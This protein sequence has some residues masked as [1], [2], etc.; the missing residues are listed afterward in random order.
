[1]PGSNLV[2]R[3]L[4]V[5]ENCGCGLA[6]AFMFSPVANVAFKW[7]YTT[8]A[9]GVVQS[10]GAP[11]FSLGNGMAAGALTF[12]TVYQTCVK[13][14]VISQFHRGEK[15]SWMA[16]RN[17]PRTNFVPNLKRKIIVSG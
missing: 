10:F 12:K 13:F 5:R 15:I 17:G 6:A 4:V 11:F 7:L 8:V 14:P 16:G 9:L 1:M 3:G 2:G